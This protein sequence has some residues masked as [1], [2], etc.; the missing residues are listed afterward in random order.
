MCA[1]VQ[2]GLALIDRRER[3]GEVVVSVTI[4]TSRLRFA[5]LRNDE[6]TPQL[7]PMTNNKTQE[8]DVGCTHDEGLVNSMCMYVGS[9]YS[10]RC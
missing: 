10:G 7:A 4:F 5:E 1:S 3:R 6:H 8:S 9:E 2:P